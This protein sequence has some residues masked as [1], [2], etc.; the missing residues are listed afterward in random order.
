MHVLTYLLMPINK[1]RTV[2]LG[3]K[4]TSKFYAI[5]LQAD[6]QNSVH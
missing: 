1:V 3:F 4:P 5:V 6:H 2:G